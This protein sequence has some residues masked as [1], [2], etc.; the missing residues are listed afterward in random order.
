MS[1]QN[2]F[3]H[4]IGKKLVKLLHTEQGHGEVMLEGLGHA[5]FFRTV[6]EV[7]GGEKFD[8]GFD[9][10]VPWHKNDTLMEVTHENWDVNPEIRFTDVAI[11]EIITDEA[12]ELM[13]RLENDTVVFQGNHYGTTLHIMKYSDL[14]DTNGKSR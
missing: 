14:F 4:L 9:W 5:Y 12:G 6:F 10:I 13:I 8:F 7:E 11:K 1:E 2:S 3:K